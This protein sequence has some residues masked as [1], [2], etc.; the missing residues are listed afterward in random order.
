MAVHINRIS[1]GSV[2][3]EWPVIIFS[4]TSLPNLTKACINVFLISSFGELAGIQ[5]IRET[6]QDEICINHKVF[7]VLINLNV[8][9][10]DRQCGYR[11]LG[12]I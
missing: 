11:D 9:Y 3:T 2:W 10:V 7:R 1:K 5:R 6:L 8:S 12:D 4:C